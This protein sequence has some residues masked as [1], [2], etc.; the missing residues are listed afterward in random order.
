[1]A[2]RILRSRIALL[3]LLREIRYSL[4]RF[5][6]EPLAAAYVPVFQD[7]RSECK[8]VILAEIDILEE[9]SDANAAVDKADQ[10]LDDFAGRVSRAVEDYTG[11]NP[12]HPL[13][14]HLF[15]GLSLSRFRRPVLGKQLGQMAAWGSPL[16]NTKSPPLVALAA[17]LDPLIIAGTAAAKLQDDSAKT[18]REF[19]DVGT[20]KQFI[21]KVNANR[22]ESHG[23][24]AKLPF[25]KPGL[26][27]DFAD[28][29][30]RSEPEADEEETMEDVKAAITELK[31]E[32]AKREAELTKMEA[33][34]EAAAQADAARKAKEQSLA[35]LEAQDAELREKIAAMKAELE[36]K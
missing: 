12:A 7:L 14:D 6:S 32:L 11:G 5:I 23:A 36:K 33:D 17:E 21:D 3:S 25:E 22:K 4:S 1:M 24:L 8:K 18:N 15:K 35:A 28:R 27:S 26:P 31:T 20:R 19:R 9:I 30:Y 13:R 2:A 29:F 34:A 10:D 16:A